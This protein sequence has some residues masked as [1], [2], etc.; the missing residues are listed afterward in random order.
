MLRKLGN[1]VI[2]E[3]SANET[4]QMCCVQMP[5]LKLHRQIM[6][7]SNASSLKPS[8][9]DIWMLAGWVLTFGRNALATRIRL[10]GDPCR[11]NRPTFVIWTVAIA[12]Y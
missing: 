12:L 1:G 7:G 10:T 11:S 6:D 3:I 4:W 5:A 2:V 9:E 8:S